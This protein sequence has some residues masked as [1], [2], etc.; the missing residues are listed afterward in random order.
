MTAPTFAQSSADEPELGAGPVQR[1]QAGSS[2]TGISLRPYQ[3]RADAA[4]THELEVLGRRSTL[5]VAC[6]GSGKT[7][8]FVERVRRCKSH[9]GRSLILAHR[10]ELIQQPRRKLEALGIHP[11]VEKGKQRAS[12]LAR[13][14]IASVQSLRG[15]RLQRFAR[16]HFDLIIVD[17][18]HH[19][20]A[21]GYRAI[22]D[23][24]DSAKV[25]GVTATPLRADGEA[26]GDVFESVAFRYEIRDAIRDQWLVPIVA[27][28]V[29]LD[30]VDLSAV[31]TRAGDLAQDQLAAL[32]ETERAISGVVVPLLEL[33]HD[34]PTV[35]FGVD[36]AH[37][38]QLAAALNERRPG[39]ARAVHGESDDR[40]ELLAAFARGE[41]QFLVNCMLLLEGWD[42]PPASCVAIARPTKSWA[43]FVQAV[44]RGTRIFGATYA[45]SCANGKRNLL[46]LNFTGTAGRHRLIGPADCLAG[47][48]HALDALADD[49]R[50]ELDRLL[51]TQTLELESVVAHATAEVEKRRAAI[52]RDAI[53]RFHAEEL[54]PFLGDADHAA[55][56]HGQSVIDPRWESEP[57]TE[58][59]ISALKKAGVTVGKLP[60]SL[61]KAEASRLLGRL[62]A[63]RSRGL[64]S[65][66]QARAIAQGTGIDARAIT[67][68][69][70]V[71]LCTM[72]R[73][74]GWRPWALRGTP[75][76]AAAKARG[77][78]D[79]IDTEHVLGLADH[80]VA[81]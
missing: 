69:R 59:Q 31:K 76:Y 51:G 6:T 48:E 77:A 15:A 34:R 60:P 52:A 13:V 21:P 7:V 49:V 39:C 53:V 14:V 73:V 65:L 40:D 25:L 3:Q 1:L 81:P 71:V 16:D 5:L 62:A 28:R 17:E 27:R 32:L 41:F 56:L 11:D 78:P 61:S 66:A 37:A 29:V 30:G 26:L 4:I 70:A 55:A 63:R 20:M 80:E 44:G 45:E 10:D 43:L 35:V 74:G 23:H 12:T 67:F 64:C 22:L 8:T 36:V 38:A 50:E 46:L 33:T 19:A 47:S 54:D 18:A 24:F 75:E 42:C 58:K 2:S 9:G 79:V 68:D 57:A 72:L